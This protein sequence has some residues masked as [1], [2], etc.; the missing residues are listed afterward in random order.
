MSNYW[1]KKEEKLLKENFE[2][3]EWEKLLSLLP[4]K[5]DKQILRKASKFDLKRKTELIE[6]YY[7]E[8]RKAWKDKRR[9]YLETSIGY[10]TNTFPAPKGSSYEETEKK[11]IG[12]FFNGI[13][14]RFVQKQYQEF[15]TETGFDHNEQ[16]FR[17][18]FENTLSKMFNQELPN[19]EKRIEDVM[20]SIKKDLELKK[21]KNKKKDS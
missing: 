16:L 15:L 11:Y 20:E 13:N 9:V 4:N 8:D 14:E 1:N 7:D 12:R 10:V 19:Q 17:L 21:Y 18:F 5:S 3:M 2:T 6:R